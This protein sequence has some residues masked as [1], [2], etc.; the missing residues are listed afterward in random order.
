MHNKITLAL[1]AVFGLG[2]CGAGQTADAP[3][4]PYAGT[5]HPFASEAVYFVVTDRFVDGDPS[6]NFE[7]DSGWD[8]PLN[9]D[10]GDSANVGFLGGDWQGILNNTDYIREMGFSSVWITPIVENPAEAFSGGFPITP[11]GI[12]TDL[13][14]SA[15]HGYW[16]INFYKEDKHWGSES[17]RFKDFTAAMQEQGLGTV[18]DIV[19]N[20]GS[21]AYTMPEPQPPYGQLFDGEGKLVADHQNLAPQDLD[22]D[23][24]PLHAF[25]RNEP[26]LAQLGDMDDRK[27]KVMDYFVGAYLQWIEQGATAFRV[28]TVRHVDKASWGTFSARIREQHPEFFMF[29]EVFDYTAEGIAPYTYEQNGGMSV[30][31]FPMKQALAGVFEQGKGFDSLLPTLHLENGAYQN[32]YELTTFYDNHDMPRMDADDNGFIDA[33]NW[34]FTARGIP[35]V[36]YGS[37]MGFMRGKAEHS[38]NRNYFGQDGVEAARNHPIRQ[39]LIR[40]AQVRQQTPALQRGLQVNLEFGADQ[41]AF[42]R[43]VQQA[44]G[45]QTA[46]VLLNKAD[47][48]HS[49]EVSQYLQPGQWREALSGE[50]RTLAAGDSLNAE[51]GGH[52]VQVWV[53][54]GAIEGEALIAELDRLMA[55]RHGQLPTK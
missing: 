24:N 52:G 10:N 5:E 33:H 34:L 26:D 50:Q 13:G 55:N 53:R 35:V 15:Y 7:Q 22:P 9:W 42:Y 45:G 2:G 14:K 17:L 30:L 16:G 6:N 25:F 27:P 12:G 43:V 39:S 41:A 4:T 28:D 23:N 20:H 47:D 36:Y 19:L 37:E 38:G 21:P 46:L 29:G 49:F 54:D 44:E 51:V 40:I 8:I 18:L 1:M 11:G 31:D 3:L 32:P 48:A